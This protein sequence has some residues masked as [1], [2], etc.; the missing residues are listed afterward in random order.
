[1]KEKLLE[2]YEE[3]IK[4]AKAKQKLKCLRSKILYKHNTGCMINLLGGR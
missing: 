2:L 4:E 3:C 1:M